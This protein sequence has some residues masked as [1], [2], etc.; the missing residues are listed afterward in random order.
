MPS[1]IVIAQSIAKSFGTN[2]CFQNKAPCFW[3]MFLNVFLDQYVFKMHWNLKIHFENTLWG[4]THIYNK[5]GVQLACEKSTIEHTSGN[6]SYPGEN[7]AH[8]Q[9]S[10]SHEEEEI[11]NSIFEY[12]LSRRPSEDP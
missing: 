5:C 2:V 3:N 4:L 1:T 8:A 12:G 11:Q 7:V 9:P 6:I 10:V